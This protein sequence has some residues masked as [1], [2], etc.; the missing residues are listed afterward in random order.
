MTN[1]QRVAILGAGIMG[2][3]TALF[4]ARQ[5]VQ[6]TLFDAADQPF[7][8]ASRWNEGKIHLGYLY[9]ADPTL[10]TARQVI[11]GGLLF[12]PLVEQLTGCRLADV[13][14]PT[15]DIFLCHKDSVVSPQAMWNYYNHV[16]EMVRQQHHAARYIV[17]VSKCHAEKLAPGELDEISGSPDIIAGFRI[18]EH[19]VETNWVADRF[20][21]ALSAEPLIETRMNIHVKAVSPK[22]A[23]AVDGP[24]IV[25]SSDGTHGPY[26]FIINALWEGRLA[27]DLTAGLKPERG[28]SNRYRLSLFLRTTE[29]QT[30]PSVII[31]TGPFGDIKNYNGRDFYLSWYLAGLMVDSHAICPPAPPAL[32]TTDEQRIS[33]AILQK[34]GALLPATRLLNDHV[35]HMQLRGG[36]VFASGQGQLSDPKSTLHCRSDF[37]IARKGTYISID[38]GKYS[39][40]PWL[41]RKVVDMVVG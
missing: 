21:E 15:K 25:T 5:G 40:A 26:D 4:L 11:P 32:S 28:W 16:A 1:P 10:K 37:G 22:S 35:E 29:A 17:D 41:A 24:W 12:G 34:L 9:P 3:S 18:P 30:L 13:T 38:T 33:R 39:T 27:I 6:V 7:S 14:T 36:W 31:A 19:S 2:S 23:H 20:V 8:G